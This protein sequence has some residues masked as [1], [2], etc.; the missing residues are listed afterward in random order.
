MLPAGIQQWVEE[1]CD[2][3]SEV[4]FE[5]HC[6]QRLLNPGVSQKMVDTRQLGAVHSGAL[7]YAFDDE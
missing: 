2:R 3:R 5:D 7:V 6:A 4:D 1:E